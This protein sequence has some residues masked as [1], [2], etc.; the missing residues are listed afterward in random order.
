[1]LD[2]QSE[3]GSCNKQTNIN[4]ENEMLK[5]YYILKITQLISLRKVHLCN[6]NKKWK[7][8]T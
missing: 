6:L 4:S 8:K 3:V 5:Y 1:M 2:G 7:K